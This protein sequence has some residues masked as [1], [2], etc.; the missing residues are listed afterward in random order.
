[1]TAADDRAW[2]EAAV[3]AHEAGLLR[4]ATTFVGATAALDVVQDTF[5]ELCTADR[6]RVEAALLAKLERLA[7]EAIQGARRVVGEKTEQQDAA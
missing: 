7:A 6:S 5:V 3:A 4:F 1:M 2:V